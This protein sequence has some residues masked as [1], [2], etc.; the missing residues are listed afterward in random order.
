MRLVDVKTNAEWANIV[1]TWASSPDIRLPFMTYC[2]Q[3]TGLP[4]RYVMN[5]MAALN[6]G[7]LPVKTLTRQKQEGANYD[8][9]YAETMEALNSRR[10]DEGIELRSALEQFLAKNGFDPSVTVTIAQDGK[11]VDINPLHVNPLRVS[12]A[13]FGEWKKGKKGYAFTPST[14]F[15]YDSMA[16]A[17]STASLFKIRSDVGHYSLPDTAGEGAVG[18]VNTF[19]DRLME[20]IDVHGSDLQEVQQSEAGFMASLTGMFASLTSGRICRVTGAFDWELEEGQVVVPFE[21]EKIVRGFVR[22]F[23]S[24]LKPSVEEEGENSND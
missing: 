10:H 18:Y 3:T 5:L 11:T 24:L 15:D 17:F 23:K 21:N 22:L 4:K 6:N 8:D 12:C 19:K 1:A 7:D 13:D 20:W 9:V 2:T 16:L 14:S